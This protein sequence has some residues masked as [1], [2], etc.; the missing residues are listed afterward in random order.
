MNRDK[1]RA[2]I[3]TTTITSHK[4]SN[5]K[6]QINKARNKKNSV[7]MDFKVH[8]RNTKNRKSFVTLIF[9]TIFLISFWAPWI[10]LWPINAYCNSC[11]PRPIYSFAYWMKYLNSF[12]NPI[13]LI[14]GNKHFNEKF[15]VTFYGFKLVFRHWSC[16][17]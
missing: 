17:K 10:I 8:M 6:E 1:K 16:I 15:K 13:I 3:A 12:T 4:S 11:I 9:I 7:H 2:S 14:I 5:S